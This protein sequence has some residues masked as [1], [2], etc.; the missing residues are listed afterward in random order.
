MFH[1]NCVSGSEN[2]RNPPKQRPSQLILRD[3]DVPDSTDHGYASNEGTP[4]PPFTPPVTSGEKSLDDHDY[5][6]YDSEHV[7]HGYGIQAQA[8]EEVPMEVDN[9]NLAPDFSHLSREELV[10]ELTKEKRKNAIFQAGLAKILNPDSI[11][12]LLG[13]KL[14]QNHWSN[15]TVEK[16]LEI[17]YSV[18]FSGYEL[19]LEKGW[20]LPSVRTLNR[21][22]ECMPYQPGIIQENFDVLAQQVKDLS[23][24]ERIFILS[25]DEAAIQ[26]LIEMDRSTQSITGFA[27]IPMSSSSRSVSKKKGIF[28]LCYEC[29][30]LSSLI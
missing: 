2:A 7:E 29:A 17:R 22:L 23:P 27:T 21:R 16:A 5:F 19:L 10:V 26:A 8:E 15:A 1:F 9:V 11:E 14:K 25:Y 20:P 13:E 24:H 12:I 30:S 4:P 18:G 3:S 6:M 28:L